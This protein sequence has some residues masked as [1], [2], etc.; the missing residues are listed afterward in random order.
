MNVLVTGAWG[1]LGQELVPALRE[2]G[3]GVIL[4]SRKDREAEDSLQLDITDAE[5][6][7]EVVTRS[8]AH[9]VIHSAAYTQVDA[10]ETDEATAYRVNALGAWNV[11]LACQDLD[12]PMLHVSTDYVFDGEQGHPYTEYD[13][14]NPRSVYGKS[15]LAGEL[16][17][18]QL[19]KRF[20]IVRTSWLFGHGGPNFVETILRA[21]AERP[22]LKV[23]DD[24][25][26]CPT[27]CQDLARGI[28]RLIASECYG[29]YHMT[30]QGSCTWFEFARAILEA[31]GL[32]TLIRPQ[33]TA[34]L[35]RPAPR[36]AYSVLRNFAME[37]Q[38]MPLLPPWQDALMRYM[39][40]RPQA[41]KA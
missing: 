6:T 9:L 41:V 38:G 37:L 22:E 27:S 10:C 23:V 20:Y 28:T 17:V 12:I 31:G 26:G 13:R 16:H 7:R 24:Q 35:N 40:G 19:L 36:P 14:T 2:A 3:H 15:K 5:L 34:E 30:G 18:Q 8:R 4:T 33:T 1:M 21:G 25:W 39:A 29:I 11:A 32:S